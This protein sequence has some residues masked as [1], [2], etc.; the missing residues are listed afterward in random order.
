MTEDARKQNVA[1]NLGRAANAMKAAENLLAIDLFAD[2][3]SRAY[4]AAFHYLRAA[5]FARGLEARTH[6]GALSLFNREFVRVGRFAG[7]FNRVYASLQRSRE[8]ADYD[9]AVQF[10]AEDARNQIADARSFG[11]DILALLRNEG[12]VP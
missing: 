9:P 8:L 10:S 5:L 7:R 1:D 4:Y 3:I 6:S 11:D 2:A 12:F